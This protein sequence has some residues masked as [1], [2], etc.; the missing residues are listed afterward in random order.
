MKK[1]LS[2][3]AVLLAMLMMLA[4]PAT[5]AEVLLSASA[6]SSWVAPEGIKTYYAENVTGK[7]PSVDGTIEEGEYGKAYR[8]ETPVPVTAWSTKFQEEAPADPTQVSEYVDFY[9]AYDEENVY[10]AIYEMGPKEIEGNTSLVPM[11]SNYSFNFGFMPN[12]LTS[13]FNMEGFKTNAQWATSEF[14]YIDQG[15]RVSNPPIHA[16]DLISECIVKKTDVKNNIDVG[17]GDLLSANGNVNYTDAQCALT[18]EFKFDKAVVA[19]ALNACYFTEYDIMS[20]AMYF[21]F[22]TNTYSRNEG[23]KSQWWRWAGQNDARGNQDK[24]LEYGVY[25]GYATEIFMDLIVF[26]EEGAPIKIANPE[27]EPETEPPTTEP[28]ATEPAADDATEEVVAT[29]DAASED[30]ATE[31]ASGGCG[32]AVSFAGLALVA[33]LGACTTFVAKKKE[34]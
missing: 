30:A 29:E 4:V 20:D 2:I 34:D 15:N 28:A 25:E 13:F 26:A 14:F 23:G 31:P 21:S 6:N 19:E 24:Y 16:Y 3:V 22:T 32:G 27:G 10:I 1:F 18:I 17:F 12:D 7:A 33:A 11:R 8:V 9:F 5:A